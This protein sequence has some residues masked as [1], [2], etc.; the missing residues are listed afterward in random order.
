M[1]PSAGS[2]PPSFDV[3]RDRQIEMADRDYQGQSVVVG[4][5]NRLRPARAVGPG[6]PGRSSD[7]LPLDTAPDRSYSVPLPTESTTV[8]LV[9]TQLLIS[10]LAPFGPPRPLEPTMT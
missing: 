2:S 5:S 3:W 8:P 9:V 10:E 6:G 7:Q 1:A 4:L